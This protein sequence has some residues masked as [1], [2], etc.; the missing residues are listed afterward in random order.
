M[1]ILFFGLSMLAGLSASSQLHELIVEEVENGGSV[2][3]RTFRLYAVLESEK[4]QLHMVYGD[5]QHPLEISS[6]KP[7]YQSPQGGASSSDINR[8]L[9]SENPSVRYDSWLTI[10]ALDNYDNNTT[11][12]LINTEPFEKKGEAIKT[13][14]GAW[15]CVPG[16]EQTFPDEQR[17][18][19]IGQF[20]TTGIIQGRISVMGKTAAGEAFYANDVEF[21]AGE[22][23]RK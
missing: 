1:R 20:T 15:F 21:K 23:R 6:S 12:F 17:R 2:P 22:V 9:A 14:D 8:K 4:D 5:A 16:K 7:F 10:G 11:L 19:L 3:G 18:V 13:T